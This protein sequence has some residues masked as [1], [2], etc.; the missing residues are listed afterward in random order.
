MAWPLPVDVWQ[1][2]DGVGG[3][4]KSLMEGVKWVEV[5]RV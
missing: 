5:A 4:G 3:G 2:F 1:E